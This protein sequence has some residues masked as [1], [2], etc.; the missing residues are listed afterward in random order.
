MTPEMAFECV[1]MSTDAEVLRIINRTLIDFSIST[2]ICFQDSQA[3]RAIADGGM[4]LLV[5][6]LVDESS[7]EIMREIWKSGPMQNPN[8]DGIYSYNSCGPSI[9]IK[10]EIPLS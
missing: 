6:D 1:L 5:I 8:I 4:V 9:H 3:K 2:R 7:L 10:L